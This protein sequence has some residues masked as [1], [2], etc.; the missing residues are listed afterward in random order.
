MTINTKGISMISERISTEQQ[1]KQRLDG[2]KAIT[3]KTL[4]VGISPTHAYDIMAV[5]QGYT[6]YKTAKGLSTKPFYAWRHNIG[7]DAV[8]YHITKPIGHFDTTDESISVASAL[9]EGTP[10]DTLWEMLKDGI[11]TGDFYTPSNTDLKNY[12]SID[13]SNVKNII[14]YA[15]NEAFGRVRFYVKDEVCYCLVNK[16]GEWRN[17]DVSVS[18]TMDHVI[19]ELEAL[20]TYKSS[21]SDLFFSMS[22]NGVNV[23]VMGEFM[24]TVNS[25]PQINI[26]ILDP[27]RTVQ[28]I[29]ELD[30]VAALQRLVL[31]A[32]TID[33]GL[34]I[35][36]GTTGSGKTTVA[37]YLMNQ[38]LG[39]HQHNKPTHKNTCE[40][41]EEAMMAKLLRSDPDVI[42]MGEIRTKETLLYAL[43]S[44]EKHIVIATLHAT[45]VFMRLEA[46][47]ASE[48][49][50][51][52][53]LKGVYSQ[54]LLPAAKKRMRIP[55]AVFSLVEDAI[56]K[57][58]PSLVHEAHR[59]FSL[60][61]LSKKGMR[62]AFG[63]AFSP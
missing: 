48:E 4:G 33:S 7:T 59:M 40:K 14:D 63:M 44:A 41:D 61:V 29:N 47:G 30:N 46:L 60:G 55:V 31:R 28:H 32:S 38:K 56:P 2:V 37:S 58:V 8:P 50:L 5:S 25:H 35:L 54:C 6:N 16:H 49:D 18:L 20:T 52:G 21:V 10:E 45:D 12:P 1:F 19:N 42:F 36:G 17:M 27:R 39:L 3:L 13:L 15:I 24:P 23:D 11:P 43:K 57:H 22:H 26:T 53:R 51:L 34:L 9:L 62:Q